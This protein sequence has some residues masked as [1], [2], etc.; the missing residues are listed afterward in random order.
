[1]ELLNELAANELAEDR[2]DIPKSPSTKE[3]ALVAPNSQ[4]SEV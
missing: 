4:N 2:T 3:L 1:L